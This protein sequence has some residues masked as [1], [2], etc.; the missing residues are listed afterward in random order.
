MAG[1]VSPE[2]SLLAWMVATFWL[3]LHMLFSLWYTSL[4]PNL[5]FSHGH[6]SDWIRAHS[7]GLILTESPLYRPYLQIQSDSEILGLGLQYMNGE[8]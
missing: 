1:L 8:A 7:N 6:W 5:L 4:C 3:C 2:P